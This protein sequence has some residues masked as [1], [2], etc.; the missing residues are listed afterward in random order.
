MQN[1]AIYSLLFAVS[2][3]FSALSADAQNTRATNRQIQTLLTRIDTKTEVFRSEVQRRIVAQRRTNRGFDDS[4]RGSIDDL[5]NARRD[6][7]RRVSSRNATSDDVEQVLSRAWNIDDYLKRNRLGGSADSQWASLRS[8]LQTLAGYYNVNFNWNRGSGYGS[9]TGSWSGS[10]SGSWNNGG[11]WN[12]GRGGNFDSRITGTY[13]LN[14]AQSDDISAVLDREL[15]TINSNNRDRMRRNLERRFNS[16]NELAIEKRGQTVTIASDMAA[17]VTVQA[18][19]RS[20]SETTDRGRTITTTTTA[21]REAV[22]IATSGD[23]AN[24]FSISFQPDGRDRLRVTKQLFLENQNRTVSVTSVYDKSSNTAQWPNVVDRPNWNGNAGNGQF[25]IPNGTQ[26]NAVLRNKISSKESQVGDRFSM[27]ITSPSQY[28]GAVIEGVLTEAKSS[29]RVSGRANLNLEFDT[30]RFNGRTYSFGGIIDSA[31]ASNG[32]SI[33]I[34]NE[35]SIRD[36]NQ[37]T[38]TVTRAGIGAAV[39]A[40]IGA[41]AGGGSGAAIGAGVGAGAGAGSVLIQG[42]DNLIMDQG[43]TFTITATAPANMGRN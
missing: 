21:T 30:V 35:G 29:G 13:R 18:D 2:L 42:R 5:S 19:G 38:K 40:L 6:L 3:L 31:R 17:A 24:D 39:G 16:P 27:E 28:Q 12:D 25:Y 4:I 41:I 1:K 33:T 15:R 32:D 14:S 9:G 36:N 43:S 11:S 34:N 22:T 20:V 23:R 8:D 7:N 10:G 26:I 37:T